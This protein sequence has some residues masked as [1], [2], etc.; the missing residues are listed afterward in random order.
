MGQGQGMGAERPLMGCGASGTSL[1]HL[2]FSFLVGKMRG[3]GSSHLSF[4]RKLWP[5]MTG[6]QVAGEPTSCIAFL[7]LKLP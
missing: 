7:T 3:V 5:K 1:P 4:S 6:R 2:V